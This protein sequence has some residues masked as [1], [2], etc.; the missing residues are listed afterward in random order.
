MNVNNDAHANN[1]INQQL[2]HQQ[3]QEQ[4][5]RLCHNCQSPGHLA[6]DCPQPRVPL[7]NRG[8]TLGAPATAQLTALLQANVAR[9]VARL[10][11]ALG[12]N[13]Q[14]LR[15]WQARPITSAQFHAALRANVV[16]AQADTLAF[17]AAV[18]EEEEE[19]DGD[20]GD[21][22]EEVGMVLLHHKLYQSHKLYH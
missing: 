16:V 5:V 18:Q 14:A 4:N 17:T 2:Q 22:E 6:R 10:D 15:D 11:R 9:S 19:E 3:Q 13:L 20:D 8:P 12:S 1:G 21:E 7:D